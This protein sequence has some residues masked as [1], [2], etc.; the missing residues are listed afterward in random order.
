M[1]PFRKILFPVDYSDSGLAVAPRARD[2]REHFS[3]EL[4]VVHA[5][6]LGAFYILMWS[7]RWTRLPACFESAWSR[8]MM[9]ERCSLKSSRRS[10]VTGGRWKSCGPTSRR[11]CSPIGS[12]CT[13]AVQHNCAYRPRGGLNG[14][15][16]E[17]SWQEYVESEQRTGGHKSYVSPNA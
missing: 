2:M 17:C 16:S 5:Y 3:G 11:S 10:K 12:Y 6:G 15:R 14:R 13:H 1:L 7:M 4:A 9:S 8:P